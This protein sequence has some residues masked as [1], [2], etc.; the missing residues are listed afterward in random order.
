MHT[1][2][3]SSP[4]ELAEADAVILPGVGAFGDA[5]KSLRKMSLV[6]P[7]R[8]L[9]ASSKPIIGICLGMQLLLAGSDEFG[10]HEGLGLIAGSV[11]GFSHRLL[12]KTVIDDGRVKIP[13]VGWNRVYAVESSAKP[14]DE[15]TDSASLMAGLPEGAF[16]YFVH[17]YV[18]E[19][20]DPSVVTG[21]T[22]YG[23]LEFCSAVRSGSV[24]GFQFHPERSG[25]HGLMIYQNLSRWLSGR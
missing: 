12:S 11:R 22:R 1:V 6:E 17:S 13:Q 19:P 25:E 3:T 15:R 23:G 9:A 4:K 10:E 2:V 24:F 14:A 5:M 8:D 20:T 18:V 16:M 21:W 7:L